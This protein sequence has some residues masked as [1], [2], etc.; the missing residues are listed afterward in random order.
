[1]SKLENY[2]K[3]SSHGGARKG[4]GRKKGSANKRTKDIADKAIEEGITPLEVLL[5]IMREAMDTGDYER[6][7]RAAKDAAPYIHPRLNSVE[8]SGT[9]GNPIETVSSI[10]I[11]GG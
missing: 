7:M 9:D 8:M 2:Q 1:M 5:Q 6:A 10:K 11:C 4:A 3:K